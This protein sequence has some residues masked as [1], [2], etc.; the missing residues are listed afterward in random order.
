MRY[1]MPA[2]AAASLNDAV[3]RVTL[4]PEEMVV[5][6]AV[7]LSDA[8]VCITR[9]HR[10]ACSTNVC[11]GGRRHASNAGDL[12]TTPLGTKWRNLRRIEYTLVWVMKT[13]A[14]LS[15]M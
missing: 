6:V 5:H 10:C 4:L 13:R 9:G 1:P 11:D 14:F 8:V 15:Y 3:E 7:L 2:G 12:S